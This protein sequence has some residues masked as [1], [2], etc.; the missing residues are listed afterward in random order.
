[1]RPILILGRSGQLAFELRRTLSPL[2]KVVALDRRSEPMVDLAKADSLVAA[3]RSFRPKLIVNGAA[4]TAVDRAEAEPEL[5]MKVN[6]QAPGVL[7]EEAKKLDAGLIHYSTDYVFAGDLNRP[8][9]EDDPTGPL[10]VY[11]RTK[12]EGEEAIRAVGA[13]YW[14]LRTAWVYGERG[15]N[16]LLTMLKLMRERESLGVVADQT[17]TP[18]WSRF[19]AEVTA[20]MLAKTGLELKETLG[21]YHLTCAGHTSWYGFACQIRRRA[22]AFGLLSESV[23]QVKAISSAEYPTPAKRPAYSVLDTHALQDAF[24][25]QPIAWEEAL[26]LCLEQMAARLS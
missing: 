7:A 14:I 25:I 9:R 6:A 18:T 17:G 8:Y 16:F 20:S 13:S 10:G 12:L 1:M 19:I 21:T 15:K 24:A 5:A 3:V 4:Y 22:Q 11:G 26:E 2:G 23:A